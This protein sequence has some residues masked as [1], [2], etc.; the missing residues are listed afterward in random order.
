MLSMLD[1]IDPNEVEA[2]EVGPG[3][4]RRDLPVDRG[5][6]AWIVEMDPGAQWPHVDEHGEFGEQVFVI[7]GE[8]IEGDH[9]FGAG[10]Y[11]NFKPHSRHQPWTETGVK[12]FGMN[13]SRA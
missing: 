3:C 5:A 10:T 4:F 2:L 11:L 1:A 9:R 6:R 12:L 8:L 13:M 7:S